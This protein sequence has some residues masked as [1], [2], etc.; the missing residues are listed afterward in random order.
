[1]LDFYKGIELSPNPDFYWEESIQ[2]DLESFFEKLKIGNE[3]RKDVATY[4]LPKLT[5]EELKLVELKDEN[6]LQEYVWQIIGRTVDVDPEQMKKSES[7]SKY[8]RSKCVRYTYLLK[9][10]KNRR[11]HVGNNSYA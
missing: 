4:F 5:N 9:T 7:D 10:S 1:M 6:H 11:R 2:E 8:V 3:K